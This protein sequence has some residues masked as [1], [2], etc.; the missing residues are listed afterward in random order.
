MNFLFPDTKPPLDGP[1]GEAIEIIEKLRAL[2]SK[3]GLKRE[4]DSIVIG[5]ELASPPKRLR[6]AP[7][8]KNR[9]YRMELAVLVEIEALGPKGRNSAKAR[10]ARALAM[11]EVGEHNRSAAWRSEVKKR[12]RS[13]Q[14][15]L[16]RISLL[17]MVEAAYYVRCIRAG[18]SRQRAEMRLDAVMAGD[19]SA[20]REVFEIVRDLLAPALTR[21]PAE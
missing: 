9:R 3:H 16:S 19:N 4:A 14:N 2:C 18:E 21:I 7:K 6:G 10:L 5:R 17:E 15:D 8:V 1:L 20:E 13:R 12:T 11:A